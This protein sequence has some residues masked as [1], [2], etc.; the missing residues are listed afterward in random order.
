MKQSGA[1][2]ELLVVVCNQPEQVEVM[3]LRPIAH[4][5]KAQQWHMRAEGSLEGTAE[6]YKNRRGK[7]IDFLNFYLFVC[8]ARAPAGDVSNTQKQTSELTAPKH[9]KSHFGCCQSKT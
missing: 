3:L 1:A 7:I 6:K 9:P 4:H 5:V 2:T 8:F